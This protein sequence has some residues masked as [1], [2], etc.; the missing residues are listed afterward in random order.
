MEGA[1]PD[2]E[3]GRGLDAHGDKIALKAWQGA[4]VQM[5][6]VLWCWLYNATPL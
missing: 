3:T 4:L 1:T 5:C 6:I 2:L